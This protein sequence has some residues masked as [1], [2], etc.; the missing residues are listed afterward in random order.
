[1]LPSLFAGHGAPTIIFDKNSYTDLIGRYSHTIPVPKGI[2]IF[3]AHWESPVQKI[4]SV[5]GYKM[6]YDFYGF[7]NELYTVKYPVKGDPGLAQEIQIALGENSIPSVIERFRGIDHGAWTILKLMYPEADIPVVTMSVNTELKPEEHYRIGQSI[8]RFKEND[9]LIICS[10]GIVHNLG[11][12]KY[13]PSDIDSWAVRF[14]EW[15]KEKTEK[16]DLESIFDYR[17]S[18]PYADLAVPR[19]EH[20]INFLIALGTGDQL[21]PSKL[22]QSIFQYG[23]LSLDLWEFV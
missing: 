15:I 2:I 18:A 19:N 16:W 13:G 10:G 20:F 11:R 8:R 7:P 4:G 1:M 17:R 12:V 23:N 6:I 5:S 22:L 3:S 21:H 14:D 9:F